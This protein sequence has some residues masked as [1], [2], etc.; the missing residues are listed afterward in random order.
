MSK[1]RIFFLP[2]AI[3]LLAGCYAQPQPQIDITVDMRGNGFS[4]ASWRVP[5]GA[6]ITLH[7]SNQDPVDHDWTI[8]YRQTV[9]PSNTVDPANVYWQHSLPAG[10]SET[11]QFTAPAAAGNYQVVSSD[12]LSVGMVGK[13]TVVRLGNLK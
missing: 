1:K 10:K 7:L 2:L 8:I 3:I 4:P 9:P 6:T 11:V 5:A 12:A 13:L